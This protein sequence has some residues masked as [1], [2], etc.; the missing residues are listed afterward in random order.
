MRGRHVLLCD[1]SIDFQFYKV[2][3]SDKLV[4]FIGVEPKLFYLTTFCLKLNDRG[5]DNKK[6]LFALIE[7]LLGEN[8]LCALYEKNIPAIKYLVNNGMKVTGT[9]EYEGHNI[10]KFEY[11]LKKEELCRLVG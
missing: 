1:T 9:G 5:N 8:F 6:A 7:C 4:G 10:V 2:M 3:R 11:N